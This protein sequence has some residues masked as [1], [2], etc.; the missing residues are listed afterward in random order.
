MVP[1]RTQN[2]ILY[3]YYYLFTY[4]EIKKLAEDSGL[5]L[6]KFFRKPLIVSR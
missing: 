2:E 3:R 6:Y 1:W 5:K 4:G